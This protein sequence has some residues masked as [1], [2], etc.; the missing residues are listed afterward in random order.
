MN[1]SKDKKTRK[2]ETGEK[3]KK[4][5]DEY[6]NREKGDEMVDLEKGLQ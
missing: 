1:R 2:V 6:I 3:G 5:N 4:A